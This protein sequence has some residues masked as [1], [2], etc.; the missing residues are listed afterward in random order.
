MLKGTNS[1]QLDTVTQS[2]VKQAY[3]QYPSQITFTP[4]S[5]MHYLTL[6]TQHGV[7]KNINIRRAIYAA[8]DRAAIVKARGGS[9]VAEPGTHFIYPGVDRLRAGGRCPPAP[10]FRGTPT[11]TATW[12]WPSKR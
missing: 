8:L 3:E 7:F 1:V 10:R 9:L 2:I 6:D 12:P 11:S 4:G 5:G